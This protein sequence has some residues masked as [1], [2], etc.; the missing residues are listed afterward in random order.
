MM[1]GEFNVDAVNKTNGTEHQT[2]ISSVFPA[3]C[4][5]V[6]DIHDSKPIDYSRLYFVNVNV[7]IKR[8]G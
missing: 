4:S 8:V 6:L 7:Q 2:V 3:N 1:N 5:P